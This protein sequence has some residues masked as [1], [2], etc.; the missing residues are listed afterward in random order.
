M[1]YKKP[2]SRQYKRRLKYKREKNK[3]WKE[4]EKLRDQDGLGWTEIARRLDMKPNTVSMFYKRRKANGGKGRRASNPSARGRSEESYNRALQAWKIKDADPTITW[5]EIASKFGVTA[6]GLKTS[7]RNYQF[8]VPGLRDRKCDLCGRTFKPSVSHPGQKYCSKKCQ[9][10]AAETMKDLRKLPQLRGMASTC[11]FCGEEIDF[12]RKPD[13][14]RG[15][16][17]YGKLAKKYCNPKCRAA[18]YRA[19]RP[20]RVCGEKFFSK[21]RRKIYCSRSCNDKSQTKSFRG[22][23]NS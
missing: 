6:S 1:E 23:L 21:D 14:K 9:R 10:Q 11:L 18:F 19:H 20:C 13:G 5:E 4:I 17:R 16:R 12:N 3:L 8:S 22:T 2:S 15:A 7:I